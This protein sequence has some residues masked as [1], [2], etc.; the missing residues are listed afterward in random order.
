M[1]SEVHTCQPHVMHVFVSTWPTAFACPWRLGRYLPPLLFA[2]GDH[3]ICLTAPDFHMRTH[4]HTHN[5]HTHTHTHTNTG[6]VCRVAERTNVRRMGCKCIRIYYA[7]PAGTVCKRIKR[8][9]SV[10]KCQKTSLKQID[11]NK[12][13]LKHAKMNQKI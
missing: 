6:A 5:K 12:I 1:L 4:T 9:T 7:D 13:T 2:K 10:N 11:T 3:T 8:I